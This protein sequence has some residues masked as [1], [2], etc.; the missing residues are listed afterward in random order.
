MRQIHTTTYT[1]EAI[2]LSNKMKEVEKKNK[3]RHKLG[4][5]A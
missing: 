5:G 4:P 3:F 1:L 2:A